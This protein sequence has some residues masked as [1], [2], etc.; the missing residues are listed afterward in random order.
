[1]GK[2]TDRTGEENYIKQVAE[3]YKDLIPKKL[4]DAMMS[5]IVEIND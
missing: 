5:Y 4:Y 1:M 3:E 2:F